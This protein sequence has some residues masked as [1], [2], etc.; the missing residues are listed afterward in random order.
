MKVEKQTEILPSSIGIKKESWHWLSPLQDPIHTAGF[1]WLQKEGLYRRLPIKPPHPVRP[2]VDALANCTTGGQIRFSTNSSRLAIRVRLSAPADLYHMPA[3]G[4]CGFDCYIGPPGQQR[5]LATTQF[6]HTQ[7]EYECALFSGGGNDTKN[8][9]LNFPLYQGVE[10]VWLGIEPNTKVLAPPSYDSSSRI[11]FYGT[12]ITQGACASR[13]GTA[14]TNI[15]SRRINREFINLGFSGNGDGRP[16]L[17][18][19]VN[20]IPDPACYVLDYDANVTDARKMR[21][22]LPR[23]IEILREKNPETPILVI[24]RI[25]TANELYDQ[26]I[27]KKRL[28]KMRVQRNTVN[29]LQAQDDNNISFLDGATLMGDAL[30]ETTVDGGHP[31]DL[32]FWLM[33]NSLTPVLEK[34]LK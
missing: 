10:E 16:A 26:K 8:I 31:T 30:L 29:R 22:T 12:S 23:F 24:S 2:A 17:A 14:F 3:T 11:I 6:D 21:E 27:Y 20:E 7:R 19:I 28:E 4:Q 32:G 15:L 13:P 5:Y 25:P 18:H 33:A 1:P 34:I 9:T